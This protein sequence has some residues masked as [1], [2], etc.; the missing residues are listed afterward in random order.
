MKWRL[1]VPAQDHTTSRNSIQ[2]LRCSQS[3][4]MITNLSGY[5]LTLCFH[6]HAHNPFWWVFT[7][8]QWLL[9]IMNPTCW[10]TTWVVKFWR[11]RPC[12]H[13]LPASDSVFLLIKNSTQLWYVNEGLR[14]VSESSGS[15]CLLVGEDRGY[16]PFIRDRRS[17]S[18]RTSADNNSEEWSRE[19]YVI[20]KLIFSLFFFKSHDNQLSG[21]I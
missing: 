13:T 20:K 8:F 7:V 3:H 9:V 19:V 15:L 18:T 4:N 2:D 14:T 17:L 12:L 5:N 6:Y 16:K 1:R 10:P 11:Q 21:S